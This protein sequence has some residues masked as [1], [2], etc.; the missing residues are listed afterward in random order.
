MTEFWVILTLLLF[1]FS[2]CNKSCPSCE[3]NPETGPC[4][5]AITKYYYDS[6]EGKCKEFTYGG[7][8]GTVPFDSMEECLECGCK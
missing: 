2:S 6:E 3:L 8:G 5:A 1:T 4:Y 7:C